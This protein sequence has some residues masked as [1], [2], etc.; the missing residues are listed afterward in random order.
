MLPTIIYDKI[1]ESFSECKTKLYSIEYYLKYFF[2]SKKYKNL[3]KYKLPMKLF[4]YLVLLKN[5]K[6]WPKAVVKICTIKQ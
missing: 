1:K 5:F 3:K 2:N 4:E 6:T